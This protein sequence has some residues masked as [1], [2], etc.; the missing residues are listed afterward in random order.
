MAVF[1]H[2]Q[3]TLASTSDAQQEMA[4]RT[5]SAPRNNLW[6]LR[7]AVDGWCCASALKH[8]DSAARLDANILRSQLCTL[9]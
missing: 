3:A 9:C 1:V 6:L 2:Q 5:C 7:Q 8:L 4:T